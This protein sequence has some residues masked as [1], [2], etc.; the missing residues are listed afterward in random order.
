[1]LAAREEGNQTYS[2]PFSHCR[3][4]ALPLCIQTRQQMPVYLILLPAAACW[5][6]VYVAT[7]T[8][9]VH[10]VGGM[11]GKLEANPMCPFVCWMKPA[12]QT[13][14]KLNIVLCLPSFHNQ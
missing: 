5:L 2:L 12:H 7:A 9:I 11:E 10:P 14:G 3:V 13:A 6:P 1:M 4:S 8:L